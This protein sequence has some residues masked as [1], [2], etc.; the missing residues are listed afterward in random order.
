M[1]SE[2]VIDVARLMDDVR[3]RV[4]EKRAQGAYGADPAAVAF[5][6]ALDE[7]PLAR[8]SRLGAIEGRRETMTAPGTLGRPL[9]VARRATV[10][11]A[12]PFIADLLLQINAFHFELVATLRGADEQVED[13]E[14]RV[15][16]LES[17][18]RALE[19]R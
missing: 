2:P 7:G 16:D 3:T 4:A 15:R 5:A 1:D 10:K 11:A 12:S 19:D 14:R 18:L 9:T 13:L 17:R 6:L 8:L